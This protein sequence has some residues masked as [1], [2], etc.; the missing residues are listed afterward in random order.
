MNTTGSKT[1]TVVDQN[2]CS[3]SA[4]LTIQVFPN[5]APVIS[6]TLSFCGGTST[7]LNAGSGYNNYS[8]NTGSTSQ[9][10]VVN[11]VGTYTVTVVN[12]NGCSSSASVTTTQTGAIPVSPGVISGP[13]VAGCGSTGSTYSIAPVANTSHYVWMMPAG[14]TIASGQ[15]S[16]TISVNF[17]S[18]FAGGYIE[19]AASNAC[20]QSPSIT[21]RKIYVQATATMPGPISGQSFGLCG[22]VTKTYS[23]NALSLATSYNW[24]APQGTTILSGQGTTSISL[25][26]ASGFASGNLCVTANNGCGSSPSSC[27]TLGGKAAKP[28]MITG[29][30]DLCSSS[31][32]VLYIIA[33]VPGASSYTWTVPQSASITSGQGTTSILVRYGTKSGDIT[34]KAN[35]ACGSSDVQSLAIV[36]NKCNGNQGVSTPVFMTQVRPVPEVISAYGGTGTASNILVDWTM[37]EMMVEN[38]SKAGMLYTQGFHQPF[39]LI[40]VKQT[41]VLVAENLQI[42][43]Y[44]NPVRSYVNI[45][46]ETSTDRLVNLVL[47]D[48]SGKLL[49]SKQVNTKTK[50]ATMPMLGYSAG[51]YNIV[52]SDLRG[53]ILQSITLIKGA[54]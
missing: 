36:V 26:I 32:N 9:S 39:I 46:F 10:I 33:D 21:A 45:S 18:G 49:Q 17:A 44:P 14:A 23:I 31:N 51:S 30:T 35:S 43:V 29:F 4:S 15:G 53:K 42:N 48:A 20:G 12:A 24:S 52:V 5:P 6:G 47:F 1:V 50:V 19:V 28:G 37:G 13:V 16:T 25:A 27:L 2:G 34:V 3:G 11:S 54:Q 7:T 38:I 22:P 41:S 40:P 8:W